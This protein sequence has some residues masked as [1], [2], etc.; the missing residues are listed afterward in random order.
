MK[1]TLQTIHHV[2]RKPESTHKRLF[3]FIIV[4][5]RPWVS[6]LG[7]PFRHSSSDSVSLSQDHGNA[8]NLCVHRRPS[9]EMCH[10]ICPHHLVEITIP[11]VSSAN[12]SAS[13][14]NDE[15]NSTQPSYLP[16]SEPLASPTEGPASTR[17]NLVEQGSA[18]EG[19]THEDCGMDTFSVSLSVGPLEHPVILVPMRLVPPATGSPSAGGSALVSPRSQSNDSGF[20]LL[21]FLG[22]PDALRIVGHQPLP[23]PLDESLRLSQLHF[24]RSLL[25]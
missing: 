2:C 3:V 18:S 21:E 10:R 19:W 6:N 7:A 24:D 13:F 8:R 12:F 16:L 11:P 20:A 22:Q 5:V 23:C 15:V 4:N 17:S 14:P 1:I 9:P 25:R